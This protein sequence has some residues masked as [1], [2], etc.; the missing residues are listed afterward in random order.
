MKTIEEQI[1]GKCCHFNGIMSKVCKAGVKYDDVKSDDRPIKLPCFK[2]SGIRNCTKVLFKTPEQVNEEL[3]LIRDAGL[4][5]LTVLAMIKRRP[6]KKESG[7]VPCPCGGQV[8]FQ[9]APNGHVWAKCNKC[10]LSLME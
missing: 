6:P 1:A 5:G 9:I 7:S 8:N 10:E 2:D 4:K 3:I